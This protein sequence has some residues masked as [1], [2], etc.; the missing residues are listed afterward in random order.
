M[1]TNGAFVHRLRKTRYKR[2]NQSTTMKKTI[3][4]AC[5]LCLASMATAAT[6]Q[7]TNIALVDDTNRCSASLPTNYF[8]NGDFAISFT[9]AD[10]ETTDIQQN[11]W[12]LFTWLPCKNLDINVSVDKD[13]KTWWL[14]YG[15]V[16]NWIE[17]DIEVADSLNGTFVFQYDVIDNEN[18]TYSFSQ[19][20]SNGLDL[21]VSKDTIPFDKER[22]YFD[23]GSMGIYFAGSTDYVSDVTVWQGIVEKDDLVAGDTPA[24]PE[25]TTATLSLLALAGLA[26]RR[27]RR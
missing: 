24:V 5:L 18:A 9:L 6:K 25:P 4:L 27:R 2:L 16:D 3:Y 23:M 13:E 15:V 7:A 10:L 20:S 11:N 8:T 1:T 19:L 17:T 14:E 26:A 21:I 22:D 12:D